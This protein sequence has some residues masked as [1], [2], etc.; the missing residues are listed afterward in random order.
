M[1]VARSIIYLEPWAIL[2]RC[3]MLKII[4][5]INH[6]ASLYKKGRKTNKKSGLTRVS[7]L[8]MILE[9]RQLAFS[10]SSKPHRY[11][12]FGGRLRDV[13]SQLWDSRQTGVHCWYRLA[14]SSQS[15]VVIEWTFCFQE[16]RAVYQQWLIS[17]DTELPGASVIHLVPITEL[18]QSSSHCL[19]WATGALTSVAWSGQPSGTSYNYRM[20]IV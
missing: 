20:T 18:P 7:S 14:D 2:K 1:G 9:W 3:E 16:E 17:T 11:R 13:F 12:A 15:A 8:F 5:S 10:T 4:I 19:Q 6:A